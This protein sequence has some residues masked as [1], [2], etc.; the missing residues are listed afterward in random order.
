MNNI[1]IITSR[2]FVDSRA[3]GICG[4]NL[5]NGFDNKSNVFL[6]CYTS[7]PDVD[8]TKE[9]EFCFCYK[10]K[11]KK[12]TRLSSL[13]KIVNPYYDYELSNIYFDKACEIITN[14]K[15]DTVISVYYPLE[16]L[17]AL[18]KIKNKF[19]NIKCISYEVDSAVDIHKYSS[20][21]GFLHNKANVRFLNKIYSSCD[22]ILIMKCHIKRFTK[23]FKS[24]TNKVRLIDSPVLIDYSYLNCYKKDRTVDFY[25][26][27]YLDKDYYSPEPFIELFELNKNKEN[28]RL[29]FYSRGNCEDMIR[30]ACKKD[31]RIV[32]HGYIPEDQL[33][34]VIAYADIF[35]SIDNS[36]KP[37]SIP[38]KVFKFFGMC[39]PVI[40]FASPNSFFAKEYICYYPFGFVVKDIK[41]DNDLLCSFIDN[42]SEM[43]S[44][45]FSFIKTKFIMNTPEYS[46]NLIK[47]LINK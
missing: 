26:T 29:H 15:I 17:I 39:K 37:N 9:N 25:Y 3:D 40:H 6:L 35:L 31:N 36:L 27:G 42:L 20:R 19:S 13:R 10:E 41:E 43:K 30:N 45:S 18:A 28:W 38:S 4:K 7:V 47:E 14:N 24:H 32:Q 5:K 44:V 1:L 16:T 2:C 8:M 46:A 23:T 34:K 21:L 22:Y 12:K 11:K 33:N